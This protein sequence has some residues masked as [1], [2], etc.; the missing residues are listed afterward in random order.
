MQKAKRRPSGKEFIA[1]QQ[2]VLHICQR[3]SIIFSFSDFSSF[4]AFTT[5]L[6]NEL[7]SQN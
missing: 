5:G 2:H 1:F 7:F 3:N 6:P 4:I